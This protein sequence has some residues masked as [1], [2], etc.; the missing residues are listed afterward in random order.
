MRKTGLYI[1][2][3]VT[4]SVAIFVLAGI[5]YFQPSVVRGREELKEIP[6]YTV[7]VKKQEVKKPAPPEEMKVVEQP[8]VVAPPIVEKKVE[9]PPVVKKVEEVVPPVE[10]VVPPVKPKVP[11]PLNLTLTVTPYI[12]E[13]VVIVEPIVV[14]EPTPIVVEEPTPPIEEEVIIAPIVVPP[15]VVQVPK[16]EEEAPVVKEEPVEVEE[17][18]V[19]KEEPIKVEEVAPP[20]EE[21]KEVT[22]VAVEEVIVPPVIEKR[23]YNP[24]PLAVVTVK[25]SLPQIKEVEVIWSPIEVPALDS[26]EPVIYIPPQ[27]FNEAA[28]EKRKVA[29][30]EIYDNLIFD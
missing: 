15:V 22:P 14:E 19:V 12:E 6:S 17:A 20:V 4:I 13:P 2:L 27:D 5:L 26:D 8:K 24:S 3:G 16:V 1:L 7:E 21:V 23:V 28:N 18:P 9:A 10:V 11:T 30:D 29:L 25:Q